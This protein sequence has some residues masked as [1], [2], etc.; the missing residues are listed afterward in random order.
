M[1]LSDSQLLVIEYR[2]KSDL[3]AM[4][5]REEGVLVY[6]VNTNAPDNGGAI[7]ILNEKL[8]LRNEMWMDTLKVGGAINYMNLEIRVLSENDSSV[9]ISVS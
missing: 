1:K 4:L 7:N 8:Q 5:P 2:K 9:I 6:T 3:D